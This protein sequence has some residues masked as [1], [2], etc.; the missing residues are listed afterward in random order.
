MILGTGCLAERSLDAEAI[1][2]ALKASGLD[3]VLLVAS[4]G[5]VPR[6]LGEVPAAAVRAHWDDAAQAVDVARLA[7]ARR[8]VLDLGQ[9]L[10]IDA[11]CR[12]LHALARSHP[13]LS[14]AA[15]TPS[16]GPL[17]TPAALGAVLDDLSGL[18]LGYWHRPARCHL[19]GTPDEAWL[20]VLGSRLVGMSLDD[21]SGA[22][23][24][25]PPGVGELTWERAAD[26]SGRSLDVALDIDPLPEL[27]LLRF[28]R[29]NL[30]RA[31]FA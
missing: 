1:L 14:L 29:D 17:A 3:R 25:L 21:V 24:G 6:H 5:S 30:L 8:L 12:A 7:R 28:A 10:D 18:S 15:L 26:W 23:G 27:G 11:A 31:G 20:D 4:R 13:G 2:A 16:G 19:L 9:A 22:E